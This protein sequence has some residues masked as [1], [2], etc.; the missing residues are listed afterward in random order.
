MQ[1]YAHFFEM[2]ELLKLFSQNKILEA[3]EISIQD[4]HPP[5][6]EHTHKVIRLLI[7]K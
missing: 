5:Q 7:Q 2:E 3:E 6:Q 4:N 1:S